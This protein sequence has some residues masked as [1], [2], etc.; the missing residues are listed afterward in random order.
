MNRRDR[1]QLLAAREAL[2]QVLVGH[3]DG[4]LVCHEM[5]EAVDAP[6]LHQRA[7][8]AIDL[9][10]PPGHCDVEGIVLAGLLRPL[11]PLVV[12][13]DE[14]GLRRGDHEIDDHG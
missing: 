4:V 1:T 13:G 5:L 2:H 10:A 3:H 8:V 11:P 12:G 7:H 6:I 14:R 9:I